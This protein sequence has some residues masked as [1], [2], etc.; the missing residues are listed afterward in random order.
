MKASFDSATSGPQM[1]SRF[2]YANAAS[3]DQ[4]NNSSTRNIIRNRARYEI[5]N[6]TYARGITLTVANDTIGTGPRLQVLSNDQSLNTQVEKDFATWAEEITLASKLRLGRVAK[7][8]DGEVILENVTN[9]NLKHP[10]KLDLALYEAE[11]LISPSG[12]NN[13]PQHYDGIDYDEYGNPTGY[14]LADS[15]P[16]GGGDFGTL[17]KPK[18]H[19]AN[20]IMHYFRADRPAQRRG[21]SEIQSALEL[22]NMLRCYTKS[23]LDASET[24][25]NH[26][27]LLYTQ[28]PAD[29][30]PDDVAAFYEE[31]FAR[32]MM[33]A[34]PF[35]WDFRQL[36][37]EQPTNTY[38][39]FKNEVINEIARCLNVPYN[40]AALNSSE[41]NY[42]SGRLDHQTYFRSLEVEKSII[43]QEILSKIYELWAMEYS[44]VKGNIGLEDI[45]Y[46]WYWDGHPHVDPL[47]EASAQ[48]TRLA[49]NTTTLAEEYAKQGQDW[50][51]ALEQRAKEINKMKELGLITEGETNAEA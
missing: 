44:L 11:Y 19:N 17:V 10:V 39:E 45:E 29:G 23:V 37:A 30:E 26:A 22:F 50:E 42:A 28:V 21:V 5:Q 1:A 25:A 27:G 18:L 43:E 48:E 46:R 49:N 38:K 51:V 9:E 33:K 24:A 6:S 14:W 12:Q 16:D 31:Q 41:Y 47:K 32:N 36:K 4:D 2:K 40:V 20:N 13:G 35:G 3:P 34:L 8:S 15:Y 7:M